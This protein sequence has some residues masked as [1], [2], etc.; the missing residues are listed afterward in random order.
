MVHKTL[1][2][3]MPITCIHQCH[4]NHEFLQNHIWKPIA[5]QYPPMK[6]WLKINNA[7]V[8][9]VLGICTNL[10][11]IRR[12]KH[13]HREMKTS[14]KNATIMKTHHRKKRE[15]RENKKQHPNNKTIVKSHHLKNATAVKWKHRT[16]KRDH[17]E[18]KTTQND[19][20]MV[21]PKTSQHANIVKSINHEW[22]STIMKTKHRDIKTVQR[23]NHHEIQPMQKNTI[24]KKNIAK[25]NH[26]AITKRQKCDHPSACTRQMNHRAPKT[27]ASRKTKHVP[28]VSCTKK[29][30]EPIKWKML[31]AVTRENANHESTQCKS[32][33]GCAQKRPPW[34]DNVKTRHGYIRKWQSWIDIMQ[35]HTRQR[36]TMNTAHE[37]NA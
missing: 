36:T 28:N 16:K 20:T 18:M 27:R 32:T 19:M 21:K 37:K 11:Y 29:H 13:D 33:S 1:D 3:P 9:P 7:H 26:H 31:D 5:F 17:R 34:S 2:W 23:W 6:F 10:D 4:T 24:V 35:K 25:R 30:S 15:H 12:R 14:Q 8:Q 22:K